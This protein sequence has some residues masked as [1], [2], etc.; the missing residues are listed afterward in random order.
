MNNSIHTISWRDN[1]VVMLDQR[2]LPLAERYVTCTDYREVIAAINDLTV[3]GAP[4]VVK[5]LAIPPFTEG[6]PV[7]RRLAGLSRQAH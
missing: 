3:R 2:A 7:H 5:N 4:A 6:T 1:T